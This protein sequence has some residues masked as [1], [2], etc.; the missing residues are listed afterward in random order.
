MHVYVRFAKLVL[1]LRVT[2]YDLRQVTSPITEVKIDIISTADDDYGNVNQYSETT[3]DTG[4]FEYSCFNG[5]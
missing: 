2:T 3:L 4:R 5:Y 1:N